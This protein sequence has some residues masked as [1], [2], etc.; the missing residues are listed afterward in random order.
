LLKFL[1][2]LKVAAWFGKFDFL[3][4]QVDS[5]NFDS[6]NPDAV[7]L[8]MLHLYFIYE[9]VLFISICKSV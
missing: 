7:L 2:S 5:D 9:I 8:M 1:F 3:T 4:S 6:F